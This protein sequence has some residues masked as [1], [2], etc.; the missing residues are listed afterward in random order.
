MLQPVEKYMMILFKKDGGSSSLGLLVSR[1][2]PCFLRRQCSA[3]CLPREQNT[4]HSVRQCTAEKMGEEVSTNCAVNAIIYGLH[5]ERH[6]GHQQ[7]RVVCFAM[8]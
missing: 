3:H 4:K 7:E 2:Y 6:Q 1:Y 5:I 8:L